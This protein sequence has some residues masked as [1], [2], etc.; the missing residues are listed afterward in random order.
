MI[1]GGIKLKILAFV[2]EKSIDYCLD[3]INVFQI[4][5]FPQIH[6]FYKKVFFG[7]RLAVRDV[8]S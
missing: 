3:N 1:I 2:K 8:S 4:N 6:S 5:L 7:F